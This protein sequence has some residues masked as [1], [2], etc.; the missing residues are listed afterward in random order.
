MRVDDVGLGGARR[1]LLHGVTGSGKTTLAVRLGNLTGLPWT[2]ADAQTWQP[3]WVQ[4]PDPEQRRR[5]AAVCAADSWILDSA[6]GSWSDVVLARAQLV[7]A[8]DYPRWLSL[9]RLLRRT[10][11]RT[12][13]QTRVCNGNVESWARTFSADSIVRWHFQSFANKRARLEAWEADQAGP[14]VLRLRSPRATERWVA[15]V[16]AEQRERSR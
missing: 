6:Y 16:A 7:V 3:G 12:L 4:R 14:P 15:T 8:L 10:V 13:R 1:I 9:G 2:E 11:D 5:I